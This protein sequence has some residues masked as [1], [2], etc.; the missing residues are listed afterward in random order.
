MVPYSL[1]K[2][3]LGASAAQKRN[4]LASGGACLST[5][6]CLAFT[7]NGPQEAQRG[8]RPAL[9]AMSQGTEGPFIMLMSQGTLFTK[10]VRR[11]SPMLLSQ[12]HDANDNVTEI[13]GKKDEFKMNRQ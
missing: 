5:F 8:L 12:H 3:S 11:T 2:G 4:H 1:S 9:I 7:R 13:N 6:K 10:K